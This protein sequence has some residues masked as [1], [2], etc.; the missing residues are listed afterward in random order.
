MES[1][2]EL[3]EAMCNHNSLNKN[4]VC[5]IEEMSELTKVL[6]KYLR[7]SPKFNKENLL[8][9]V[10]HVLLMCEVIAMQHDLKPADIFQI[11]EDVVR[12]MYENK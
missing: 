2:R 12:R 11:Q 6:T 8:E 3:I 4:V 10:G 5:C 1:K 7:E 9:E